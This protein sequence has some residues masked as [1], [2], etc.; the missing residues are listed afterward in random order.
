[1]NVQGFLS[2]ILCNGTL[3]KET[4]LNN[5]EHFDFHSYCPHSEPVDNGDTAEQQ[6]E[7]EEEAAATEEQT[8]ESAKAEGEEMENG[9]EAETE[10]EDDQEYEVVDDTEAANDSKGLLGG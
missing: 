1:M 8:A 7:E 9:K 10:E 5:I 2:A 3:D 6:P 4:P